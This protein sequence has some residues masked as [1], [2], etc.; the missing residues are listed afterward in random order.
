MLESLSTTSVESSV[1]GPKDWK[2]FKPLAFQRRSPKW[3][4]EVSCAK[5]FFLYRSTCVLGGALFF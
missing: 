4:E 5:E 1:H 2:S 3:R